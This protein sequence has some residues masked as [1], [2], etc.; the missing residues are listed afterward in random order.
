M[1][2]IISITK[3]A[4]SIDNKYFMLDSVEEGA[5]KLSDVVLKNELKEYFDEFYNE[6]VF[7][8]LVDGG[9]VSGDV[10]FDGNV[11]VNGDSFSVNTNIEMNGNKITGSADGVDDSDLATVG[12]LGNKTTIQIAEV[13]SSQDLTFTSPTTQL[14]AL[15]VSR[16]GYNYDTFIES[17]NFLVGSTSTGDVE[18]YLYAVDINNI[19]VSSLGVYSLTVVPDTQYTID[20]VNKILPK[21]TYVAI[22]LSDDLGLKYGTEGAGGFLYKNNNGLTKVFNI[23]DDVFDGTSPSLFSSQISFGWVG[24]RTASINLDVF[25]ENKLYDKKI[26]AIGDSMVEGAS[27]YP[28]YSWINRIH[29][30]D[31]ANVINYGQNGTCITFDNSNGL[32]ILNRY[33]D[34]DSDADYICVFGGTNDYAANVAIGSDTDSFSGGQETFKGALNDLCDGLQTKYP[35]GKIMF[36]TPYAINTLI[37]PYITAIVDICKLHSIYVFN[38]EEIGGISWTNTAQKTAL[39]LGDAYH[40]NEEGMLFASYKYSA[41]LKEL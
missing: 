12:Q 11:V 31:L 32:S 8:S 1:G 10:T 7:L 28:Q 30:N 4:S 23:D 18:L 21:E 25:N 3:N 2:R 13:N 15:I 19:V 9:T 14:G 40:L 36:I 34:M 22:A 20:N 38:N 39:R 33:N 6:E 37:L 27:I 17:F 29:D 16:I 5:E 26:V 41:K 24:Y 35:I